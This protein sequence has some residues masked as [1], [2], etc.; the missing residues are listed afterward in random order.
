VEGGRLVKPLLYLVYLAAALMVLFIASPLS[1]PYAPLY[2]RHALFFTVPFALLLA[3]VLVGLGRPGWYLGAVLL[4]VILPPL[5][6]VVGDDGLWEYQHRMAHVA[7]HV[8]EQSR[9]GDLVVVS[10]TAVRSDFAHYVPEEVPVVAL[11]PL[12]YFGADVWSSR[13]T[14]GLVENESQVRGYRPHEQV[15]ASDGTVVTR[16]AVWRKLNRLD[17]QYGPERVWLYSFNEADTEVHGWFS[18]YGWRRAEAS[19]GPMFSLD[20]YVR[21]PSPETE[22]E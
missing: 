18:E 20:L 3:Q 19:L 14:L 12:N 9:P 4:V 2:V 7:R 17:E 5:A 15:A 11:M 16:E 21:T 10:R 13:R 1:V 8:A 6:T 22:N